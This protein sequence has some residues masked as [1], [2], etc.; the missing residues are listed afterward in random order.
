MNKQ[1]KIIIILSFMVSKQTYSQALWIFLLGDKVSTEKFQMG[2]NLSAASTWIND[3][4]NSTNRITW[5]FGGFA[6]WKLN[7]HWSFQPEM[8]MK[9]PGGARNLENYE[10]DAP[11]AENQFE[12]NKTSVKLTY[13]SIPIYLKYKTKY[14]GLGF[15]PQFGLLYRASSVFEG[16]NITTGKQYEIKENIIHRTN[17]FD[18]GLSAMLEYYLMPKKKLMSMRIGIKYYYGFANITTNNITNRNSTLLI[19]LAIPV[20]DETKTSK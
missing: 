10:L 13:V 16:K 12:K 5:A 1:L 7:E 3:I 17:N 14:L 11:L 2:M 15:G 18:Y 9:N 4:E 19:T 6:E 20:G 8:I